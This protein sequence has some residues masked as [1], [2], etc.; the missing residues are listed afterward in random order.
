[1]QGHKIFAV[2]RRKRDSGIDV[3]EDNTNKSRQASANS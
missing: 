2:A 3:A 1:M